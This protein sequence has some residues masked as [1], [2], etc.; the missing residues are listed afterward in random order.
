[1]IMG[2]IWFIHQYACLVM[3][4]GWKKLVDSTAC[5]GQECTQ[6][7]KVIA[8]CGWSWSIFVAVCWSSHTRVHAL[9]NNVWYCDE[10][11]KREIPMILHYSRLLVCC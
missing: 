4:W 6:F 10:L 11:M 1:M 3:C 2:F 8:S 5:Y 7:L 9:W